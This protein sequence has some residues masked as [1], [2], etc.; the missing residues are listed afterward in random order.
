[1]F[2]LKVPLGATAKGDRVAT[3]GFMLRPNSDRSVSY[4]NPLRR[5][6]IVD[7]RFNAKGERGLHLF[8]VETSRLNADGSTSSTPGTAPD[9]NWWVVGGAAAAA[10]LVI[11]DEERKSRR[12]PTPVPTGFGVKGGG[13]GG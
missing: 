7:I 10:V 8:G 1:M 4:A 11:A 3:F 2:Y 6:P 13:I 9:V 12:V 5:V